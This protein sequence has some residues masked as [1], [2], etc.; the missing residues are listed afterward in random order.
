MLLS[1]LLQAEKDD[2]SKNDNSSN[3][4]RKLFYGALLYSWQ[5]TGCG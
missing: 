4:D 1:L 2:Q 5:D 3:E